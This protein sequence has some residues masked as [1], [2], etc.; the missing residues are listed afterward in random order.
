M[1]K[2]RGQGELSGA[3]YRADFDFILRTLARSQS[4]QVSLVDLLSDVDTRDSISI[5]RD[6]LMP[7]L[8]HCGHI[9]GS[10]L[11]FIFT[12]LARHVL[13]QGGI[14][15]GKLAITS[16]RCSKRFSRKAIAG[17]ANLGTLRRVRHGGFVPVANNT[18]R[19]Y[20]SR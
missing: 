3:V 15:D 16:G 18:F 13:Q 11:S 17:A 7:I 9:C 10:H 19:T 2:S 4:D 8:N 6:W 20:S 5:I 1:M 12:F 14:G